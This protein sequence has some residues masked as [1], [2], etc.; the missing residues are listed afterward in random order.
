VRRALAVALALA[1]P[2][3]AGAQSFTD[4]T[5]GSGLA[6]IRS[7]KPAGY[8]VS[9]LQLV[10]LDNDGDLDFFFG[11]HNGGSGQACLNDGHGH[12]T[13]DASWSP[14]EI[15][16]PY[17]LDEDGRI[18]LSLTE[19]DGGGRWWF[20]SGA[21][22]MLA[23][24]K[25]LLADAQSRGQMLADLDGDGKVDWVAVGS[26]SGSLAGPGTRVY[27]GDG[28]GGLGA[29]TMLAGTVNFTDLVDLDGD[30]DLDG[31][32]ARGNYPN[33]PP[34]RVETRI[35]RN[36]GHLVFT[37]VTEAAGLA[38]PGL[39]IHGW[40]DVDQDGDVDLIG[41]ENGG[42]FPVVI[43]LNDG[44]GVFTKKPS[45]VGGP[46]AGRAVGINPG[47][48]TVVDLDNDGVADIL[49]G[50]VAFFQVLRGTGGGSFALMNAAWG[51]ASDGQLPDSA[52]AFGDIDG[53]GDLDLVGYRSTYPTKQITL[54]RN[55]LPR[56]NWVAVRP[57][58][59]PGNH[60]A[61]GAVVRLYEPGTGKLL[62]Y[63]PIALQ[64]KQVQQ[65]HYAYAETERHYGLRDR[66]SVDVTVE[67]RPS[68]RLVKKPGV[69]AGS[70]V[71]LSESDSGA[72]ILPP[73]PGADAT[74]PATAPADGGRADGAA[75]PA[76]D[77]GTRPSPSPD[78][79]GV[80][81][82]PV[83]VAGCSCRVQGGRPGAAAL[84][85]ISLLL[86]SIRRK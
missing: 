16:L 44:H 35:Y 48:A 52:F 47:L 54:Y 81:A 29:P 59:A 65:N 49:I 50:G 86:A 13:A 64:A 41:L 69:P 36:D 75:I 61:L 58:G 23:F 27:R 62:W 73:P 30:G 74:A 67:F 20:G 51:I 71:R 14:S 53:D 40:G 80:E 68:N 11:T 66:T 72:V 24:R 55:D 3:A 32:S 7:S 42:A 39:Y 38:I 8:W 85:I 83:R 26:G 10:D 12:F 28:K 9:G 43:Y 5:A 15:H 33:S 34:E 70:M 76:A 56:R 60:G 82:R 84:V 1:V 25:S 45:A 18:D 6:A 46:T 31:I 77:A 4:V 17:D 57:I 63:E 37:D 2:A 21:P 79:A 22:G 19:N 78:A